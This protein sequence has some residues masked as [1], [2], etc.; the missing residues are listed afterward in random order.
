MFGKLFVLANHNLNIIGLIFWIHLRITQINQAIQTK[1]N[2][3]N[4]W[5]FAGF[6]G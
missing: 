2:I 3:A 5:G 1:S 6:A 4:E